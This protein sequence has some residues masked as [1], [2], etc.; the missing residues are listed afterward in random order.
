M[1]PGFPGWLVPVANDGSTRGDRLQFQPQTGAVGRRPAL[2][3][4]ALAV[5]NPAQWSF[6]ALRVRP[7][8]LGSAGLSC[9]VT[10]ML[11]GGAI[12]LMCALSPATSSWRLF[13]FNRPPSNA[14]L[15]LTAR[16]RSPPRPKPP[17]SRQIRA[18]A[19]RM[20][21]DRPELVVRR[22]PESPPD[23]QVAEYCDA[24]LS[25]NQDFLAETRN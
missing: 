9:Q 12:W 1:Q 20:G 17:L 22:A 7:A 8:G 11:P 25:P 24:I 15:Q 13:L 4:L 21:A 18:S 6:H 10:W 14:H 3:R 23:D 19:R 16:N 5:G 2:N